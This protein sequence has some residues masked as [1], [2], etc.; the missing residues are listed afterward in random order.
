MINMMIMTIIMIMKML[1][2]II[3]MITNVMIIMMMLVMNMLTS[4][5]SCLALMICWTA[6]SLL[7]SVVGVNRAYSSSWGPVLISFQSKMLLCFFSICIFSLPTPSA[8]P[9][10]ELDL[11]GEFVHTWKYIFSH[12]IYNIFCLAA[13]NIFYLIM[14][15]NIRKI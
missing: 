3:I 5:C 12:Y 11:A 2:L 13:H 4:G 7:C 10:K 14:K 9:D 1:L 15:Y 6:L 8:P